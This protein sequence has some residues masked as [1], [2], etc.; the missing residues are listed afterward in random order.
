MA[1]QSRETCDS[2]VR[3]SLVDM[4]QKAER[5]EHDGWNEAL[6]LAPLRRRSTKNFEPYTRCRTPCRTD[7]SPF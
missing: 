5:S 7:F 6:R 4:A 2:G 1:A 3:A